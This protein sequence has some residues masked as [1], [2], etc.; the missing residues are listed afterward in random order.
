MEDS[1]RLFTI[2]QLDGSNYYTWRDQVQALL[3]CKKLWKYVTGTKAL[4][5][6]EAK[7]DDESARG[8]IQ[9]TLKRNV[10]GTIRNCKTSKEAW[11]ALEKV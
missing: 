8:L 2:E 1:G 4:E 6:E 7:E 9:L 3:A 5:T 10:R 11:E